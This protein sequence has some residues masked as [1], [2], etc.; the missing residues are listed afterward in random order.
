MGRGI[1]G[2]LGDAACFRDVLGGNLG[3]FEEKEVKCFRRRREYILK[4]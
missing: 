3:F 4:K 1:E 2:S